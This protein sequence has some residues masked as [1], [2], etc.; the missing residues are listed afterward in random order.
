MDIV[1]RINNVENNY[2][3]INETIEKLKLI[4][5]IHEIAGSVTSNTIER[6]F[7]EKEE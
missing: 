1:I 2:K 7:V 5:G 6:S 3:E 4:K